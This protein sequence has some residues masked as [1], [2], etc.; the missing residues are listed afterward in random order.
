MAR[1]PA[2]PASYAAAG[3]DLDAADEVVRRI[4]GIVASTARREVLGGAGGFAGLFS[5]DTER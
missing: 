5:L 3:V 1:R 2:E 4:K